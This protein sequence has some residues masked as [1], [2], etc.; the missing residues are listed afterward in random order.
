MLYVLVACSALIFV[1]AV[2]YAADARR[3]AR[4]FRAQEEWAARL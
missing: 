3:R 1:F 4:L 2:P